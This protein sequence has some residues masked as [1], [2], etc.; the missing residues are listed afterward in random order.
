MMFIS[1]HYRYSLRTVASTLYYLPNT[2]GAVRSAACQQISVTGNVV[3]AA[4]VVEEA[5]CLAYFSPTNDKGSNTTVPHTQRSVS[6]RDRRRPL[7]P[8]DD[9]KAGF[10]GNVRVSKAKNQEAIALDDIPTT[11]SPS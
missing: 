8:A 4:I 7:R 10:K 3:D 2:N 11:T 6:S 5:S 1:R 9:S